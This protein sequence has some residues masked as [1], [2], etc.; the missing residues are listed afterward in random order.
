LIDKFLIYKQTLNPKEI[1]MTNLILWLKN[2]KTYLVAFGILVYALF[3]DGWQNG[4]WSE[5]FQKILA[6]LGLSS[7]RA[8]I[9]KVQNGK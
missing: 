1:Y 6:A 7:L 3:V 9:S 4:N 2:K 5:A 8:G